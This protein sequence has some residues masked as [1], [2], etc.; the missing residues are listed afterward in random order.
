MMAGRFLKEDVPQE[1]HGLPFDKLLML[2]KQFRLPARHKLKN[3]SFFKTSNFNLRVSKNNIQASRFGFIV[4][5]SVDKRA[6][7][8]NRVRRVFRSCIEE[9]LENVRAG[10][11]M[12]FSL[13][14]GI[15]GKER[16][17]IFEE[18]KKL[19]TEKRLLK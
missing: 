10:N 1:G 5:K 11:D 2:K 7:V 4:K 8:R 14:K 18:I 16:S 19:L 13:E 12:L 9:M 6:T 3:S 15:I 17:V